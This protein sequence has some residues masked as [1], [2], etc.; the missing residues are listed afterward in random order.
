M[1]RRRRS[2][3]PGAW[4]RGT[5][6]SSRTRCP[7]LTWSWAL[8]TTR[9][10]RTRSASSSG[11]RLGRSRTGLSAG[12]YEWVPR[13][14]RSGP[15]LCAR[16]SPRSTTPTSGWRRVATTSARSA[17]SRASGASSGPSRGT[18]SSRR[19]RRSR[20]PAPGSCASSRRTPTSGA[21]TSRRATAAG[22]LSCSKRWPKWTASSGSG[23]C[24]R[25]RPTSPRSSSTPSRT[26]PRWPSTST[27][28]CSTSP[29]Y[30]CC[31]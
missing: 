23:S 31:A 5:R 14:P 25:T 7:R 4:R 13:R 1:E 9:I 30:L 12:G 16:G 26:F 28:P 18:R 24:T 6:T 19:P 27:S 20:T 10:S 29:T 2:S 17:P 11:W 3:S 22:W 15:R 8:K 21:W